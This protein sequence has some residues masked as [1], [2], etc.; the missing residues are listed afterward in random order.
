MIVEGL[1]EHLT[2]QGY[3]ECPSIGRIKIYEPQP[4]GRPAQG[5]LRLFRGYDL[6]TIYWW[7]NERPL[8]GLVVDVCWEI[9]DASGRRLSTP[10]IAQYN[11]MTEVSRLREEYLPDNRINLEVARLRLQNHILSF[12][13]N[14]SNFSLPCGQ[15][16]EVALDAVPLRV[17]IGV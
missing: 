17:V 14:N 13:Q 15:N 3:S 10:E 12:V 6:R 9:Q 16:I 7:R 4:F 11:A 8:F 2:Q 1:V 5:R